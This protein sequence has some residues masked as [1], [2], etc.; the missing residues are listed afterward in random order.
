VQ[1]TVVPEF[2]GHGGDGHARAS[3]L[4]QICVHQR[5]MG[6][7]GFLIFRA[8]DAHL[9][10]LVVADASVDVMGAFGAKREDV[11][12]VSMSRSQTTHSGKN[13]T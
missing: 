8:A 9:R 10:A 7:K 6:F 3:W 1:V 4:C 2:R 11:G 12:S 13:R 5:S